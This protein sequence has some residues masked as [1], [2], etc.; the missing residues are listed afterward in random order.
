[1]PPAAREAPDVNSHHRRGCRP[2]RH[3]AQTGPGPSDPSGSDRSDHLRHTVSVSRAR[4]LRNS[5]LRQSDSRNSWVQ[6]A[7]PQERSS[8][9]TGYPQAAIPG[10]PAPQTTPD[11]RSLKT[12]H[13]RLPSNVWP[14][15]QAHRRTHPLRFSLLMADA[16]WV[17]P[18][19]SKVRIGPIRSLLVQCLSHL[20][21]VHLWTGYVPS[22]PVLLLVTVF[23]ALLKPPPKVQRFN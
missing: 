6:P 5:P 23:P 20:E 7:R 19:D 13:Q 10:G 12:R 16:G 1:M 15:T 2:G 14:E 3:H 18:G 17:M 22:E 21:P 9:P 8:I 4:P 11:T